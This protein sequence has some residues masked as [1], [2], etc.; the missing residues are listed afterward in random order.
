MELLKALVFTM[1]GFLLPLPGMSIC[2]GQILIVPVIGEKYLQ[3]K[4]SLIEVIS[5]GNPPI[6][7]LKREIWSNR[8]IENKN[9]RILLRSF[10]P[11]LFVYLSF[12]DR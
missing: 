11:V 4:S 8:R 2:C 6:L 1:I 5:G 10:L 9:D 7:K 12:I 3:K